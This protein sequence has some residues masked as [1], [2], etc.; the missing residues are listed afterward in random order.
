VLPRSLRDDPVALRP[1]LERSLAYTE[2]LPV[3]ARRR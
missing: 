2:A 3:K 1:W